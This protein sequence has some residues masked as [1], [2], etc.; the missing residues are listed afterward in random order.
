MDPLTIIV[1]AVAAGAAAS[2]KDVVAQAV[3]DGYA[4]LKALIVRK[5]GQKADVGN[6]LEGVEKRPDSEARQ[7]VL[8]E[9]LET[10]GAGQDAEVIRQA[11][12]LLELLKQQG[13]A[14]GVSYQAELHGSGFIAQG[15]GVAA[16]GAGGVAV[17]G[18]VG[19]GIIVTGDKSTVGEKDSEVR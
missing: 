19:G 10:A 16:A 2:V 3:M 11:G 14:A 7:A 13:V 4:S 17:S 8:K 5:F 18:D 1:S 12:A 15:E 6:A 9:E